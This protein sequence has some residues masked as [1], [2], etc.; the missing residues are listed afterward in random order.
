[1][2]ISFDIVQGTLNELA[3]LSL[4]FSEYRE[5]YGIKDCNS[6]SKKF[7]KERLINKDSVIFLDYDNKVACGFILLYF[8]YS[9]LSISPTIILNDL[10]IIKSHR[11]YGVATQLMEKVKSFADNSGDNGITLCTSV[12][13]HKAR[14][15]YE[16]LN[17]KIGDQFVYYFLKTR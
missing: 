9:S 8:T 15:L 13:N 7:I 6:E 2:A 11:G 4:L 14:A 17:D 1:M 10:C 5:F 3:N 16:K 12:E